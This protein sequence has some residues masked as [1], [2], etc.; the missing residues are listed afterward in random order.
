V[1]LVPYLGTNSSDRLTERAVQLSV[2]FFSVSFQFL[3]CF[4]FSIQTQLYTTY[5]QHIHIL[6]LSS[7]Y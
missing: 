4:L 7:F 6:F 1:N 2:S 5:V 3:L